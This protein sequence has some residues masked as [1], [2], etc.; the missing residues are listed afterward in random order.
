VQQDA[1]ATGRRGDHL[2]L[3]LALGGDELDARGAQKVALERDIRKLVVGKQDSGHG[4]GSGSSRR[5][6]RLAGGRAQRYVARGDW[7]RGLTGFRSPAARATAAPI[8]AHLALAPL[9]ALDMTKVL[10]T[11]IAGSL[12]KPRWLA[13]PNVLW[14]P[15][16]SEGDALAEGIA[17]AVRLA[18]DDQEEAGIDIVTDGEQTAPPLRHDVPGSARR[19]RLRASQ[20]RPNSQSLRRGGAGGRRP[21]ARR[22]P[23]F[24][25]AARFLRSAT[26][27]KI[28]VTL[29][30]PMTLVDYALRRALPQPRK[31]SPARLRRS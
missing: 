14:A 9:G 21:V 20:N 30:G 2:V 12:P 24:V 19:R 26:R 28:K 13:E 1:R 5:E 25:D 22:N 31:S 29:P 3:R 4:S 8:I 23:V 18:V 7:S 16:R 15:W 17:D 11:T 27:R 10:Q 6:A